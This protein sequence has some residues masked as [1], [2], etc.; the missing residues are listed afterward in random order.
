MTNKWEAQ[1]LLYDLS[2]LRVATNNLSQ[3]NKHGEGGFGPVY[4]VRNLT[5]N[6]QPKN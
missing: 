6:M 1:S 4:K 5:L 2:T 3:E